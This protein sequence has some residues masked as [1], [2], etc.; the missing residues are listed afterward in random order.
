[1]IAALLLAGAAGAMETDV[2]MAGKAFAPAHVTVLVG[3]RVSWTNQ[4]STSHTATATERSFDSGRVGPG[5]TYSRRFDTPGLVTYKCTLHRFMQGTIEVAALEL[6]APEDPVR[7]GTPAELTGRAPRPGT[8]VTLERIGRGAIASAVAGEDGRFRFAVDTS[9]GPARYR[10]HAGGLSSAITAVPVAPAVR[11]AARRGR[12]G[13]SVRV[14]V[15]PPQPRGAVVLERHERERFGYVP[16]RG[17][18]LDAHSRTR[19][20]LHTSRR[21]RLRARLSRPVAGWSRAASAVVVVPRAG[22]SRG[23]GHH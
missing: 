20:V 16:L 17:R 3:E 11:L 7:A 4:D 12:H 10:A 15:V 23:G 22:S 19:L 14:H 21:L 13:V 2:A 8:A 6:S 5:G 9:A 1:M 18:R